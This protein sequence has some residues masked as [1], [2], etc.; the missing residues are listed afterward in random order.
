MSRAQFSRPTA[1]VG[2]LPKKFP[3]L[4]N[5]RLRYDVPQSA[6]VDRT[7]KAMAR[8]LG[9]I[10]LGLR[11][12]ASPVMGQGVAY[13]QCGGIGWTGPSTCV[14]GYVCTYSN[15]YYSQCIPGTATQVTSTT[16]NKAAT[17]TGSSAAGTTVT[18]VATTTTSSTPTSST[19][20]LTGIAA[21][22]PTTPPSKAVGQLPALGWNGW[23]AYGCAITADKVLAAAQ[24]FIDLGLADVGYEYLNIDDCWM[25]MAR[26]STT[27][28][29]VPDPSK[30]P[31][32]MAALADKVHD[33]GFKIGIYS[34]AGTATCA[35]F[36]GGLGYESIDAAAY[37]S[38]DLKYD[39]C[40]V[41]S[42]WSDTYPIP[43]NDYYNSNTA[44]RYRQMGAAIA[45]NKTPVQFSLCIWG[46]D[47]PYLWG[48]KVGHS[49]RMSGDSS[50]SWSYITQIM[51]SNAQYLSYVT[52][53]AHNDMDMMEIGNGDLTIEEQRTHF[54]AWAFMK[55]PILLGTDL[56]AL[57]SDQ[58][59]II[60]NAA[61]IDFHQDSKVGEPAMP[62]TSSTVAPTSPPSFYAGKSSKGTHF[63]V[64][65][66]NSA[67]TSY[68]VDFADVT[69]LGAGT[70]TLEDMWTGKSLGSF[71]NSYTVSIAAHDTAAILVTG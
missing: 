8:S 20:T 33:M 6:L 12:L 42:N 50:A 27:K 52:F 45:G 29:Q 1:W 65:N 57:S 60:T 24:S 61:L 2:T 25:L 15:D 23:N 43:N 55:S 63:F 47:S 48:A 66:L 19:S 62:F 28:Q 46:V 30:F 70:Y 67:T 7:K 41:P 4:Y 49:W 32:G 22:A 53:G 21:T 68:T 11:L 64:V 51:A 37:D 31:D 26:D 16:S 39:N 9:L 36:P 10:V 58:V 13:S 38:W 3:Y 35:G 34:D 56:S 69:G 17:S 5:W 40:N 18:H 14:S 44:I 54:A 71:T 59:A